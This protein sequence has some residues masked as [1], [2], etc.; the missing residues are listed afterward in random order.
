MRPCLPVTR[1]SSSLSHSHNSTPGS[2]PCNRSESLFPEAGTL[3]H[4]GEQLVKL[5]P[6]KTLQFNWKLSDKGLLIVAIPLVTQIFLLG[7]LAHFISEADSQA[8]RLDH[9]KNM[10][11]VADSISKLFYDS[12]NSLVLYTATRSKESTDRYIDS[13]WQVSEHLDQLMEMVASNAPQRSALSR[14]MIVTNEGLSLLD[15]MKAQIDAS[16]RNLSVLAALRMPT[17]LGS[18]SNQL[19]SGLHEFVNVVK[20]TEKINPEDTER[21]RQT[22]RTCLILGVAVSATFVL[23]AF[24]FYRHMTQRL[25]TLMDNTN[26]LVKEE[27]LHPVLVGSDEIAHLDEVFHDMAEALAEATSKEREAARKERAVIEN[28]VDVICSIDADGR[29]VKV[30]PAVKSLL[31]YEPEE[32]LETS[33]YDIVAT[34]D[35][36]ATE[37]SLDRVRGEQSSLSFENRIK[38]KEGKIVY[39]S[40]SVHWSEAEQCWFCVAH[41]ITEAKELENLK[42]QF[43]A[44]LSH[45][46][47]TPLASI[48]AYFGVLAKG[49]YGELNERGI[50]R[51]KLAENS[52]KRLI[53]MVTDL[54]DIEKVEAGQLELQFENV[55]VQ[56]IIEQ[57]VEA[58]RSFAEQ[59]E[60]RI[61]ASPTLLEI[62]ADADRVVRVLV[63]LLGNAV[64]FSPPKSTISVSADTIDNWVEVR[65]ADQGRGIPESHKQSI[66][67]R[68]QQVQADDSRAKG[69][70]GL[71]LAICKA[72]IEAH[73]GTIGVESEEEK[74]STFWFRLRSASASSG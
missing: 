53:G 29:F 70:S 67:D 20:D 6:G 35:R 58:V 13:T 8:R 61:E 71:G 66:F 38:H 42:Q 17:N 33:L 68:F 62:H 73:G 52:A 23:I 9:Y 37:Q 24:F 57:S 45:D 47:R 69:G 4:I 30:N 64:K 14:V 41:D 36:A 2:S 72:I 28:A 31:G 32:L 3:Y 25:T 19:V 46:L 15:Q 49:A 48:R 22:V 5:A 54:L 51:S 26:R 1:K 39:V 40:W 21:M 43:V 34:D 74:G 55:Q 44:M 60:I 18:V 11:A 7:A 59:E 50:M 12:V 65:V 16:P 27:P 10:I 63:N 56:S